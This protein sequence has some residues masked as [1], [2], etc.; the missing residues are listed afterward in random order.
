MNGK[1]FEAGR[2][3]GHWLLLSFGTFR[4][5]YSRARVAR[6]SLGLIQ[7]RTPKARLPRQE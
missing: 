2:V 5:S 3:L 6:Q 4:P 7:M 1:R